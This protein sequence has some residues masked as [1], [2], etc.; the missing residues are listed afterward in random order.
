MS[1]KEIS[2]LSIKRDE[3]PR[4]Q[5]IW[6]NG[7]HTWTGTGCRGDEEV[8]HN[9]VCSRVNDP[10]CINRKYLKGHTYQGKDT[11]EK[12]RDFIDKWNWN[13]NAKE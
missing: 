13:P 7:Q 2:D 6:L 4:C 5:A 3:C 11:W 8:L 9:L 12:R 1:D 10:R